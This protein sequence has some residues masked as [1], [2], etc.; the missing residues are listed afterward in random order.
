MERFW[1]CY[2]NFLIFLSLHLLLLSFNAIYLSALS[3]SPFLRLSPLRE[4]ILN[5]YTQYSSSCC[6]VRIINFWIGQTGS[7]CRYLIKIHRTQ[8]D[9]KTQFVD[10]ALT[11][12][13]NI[14]AVH[15]IGWL[16]Y[17]SSPTDHSALIIL[18]FDMCNL[19]DRRRYEGDNNNKNNNNKPNIF[20]GRNDFTCSTNCKN[21]TAEKLCTLETWFV[22][23]I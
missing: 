2:I 21:R 19:C 12:R 13:K 9:T 5:S 6:S 17:T 3:L 23:G 20:H 11:V 10:V 14:D 15:Y 1:L 4:N 16:P 22:S 8:P 18:T 7:Y